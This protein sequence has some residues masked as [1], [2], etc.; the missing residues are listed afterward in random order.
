MRNIVKYI[1]TFCDLRTVTLLF[2]FLGNYSDK[3][4]L[5]SQYRHSHM[6]R[7][8]TGTSHSNSEAQRYDMHVLGVWG[9]KQLRNL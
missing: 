2:I 5:H 6:C 4:N 8:G 7:C 3:V 1:A 9:P